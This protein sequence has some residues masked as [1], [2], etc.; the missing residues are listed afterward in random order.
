M[1]ICLFVSRF[2]QRVQ[3]PLLNLYLDVAV[4]LILSNRVTKY[5]EFLK[6]F[7]TIKARTSCDFLKYVCIGCVG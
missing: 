5:G 6:H 4:V 1:L 3:I 7:D 2:A